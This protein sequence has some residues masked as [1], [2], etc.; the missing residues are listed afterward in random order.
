MKTIVILSMLTIL[1]TLTYS[2]SAMDEN[3]VVVRD[4]REAGR[5]KK[6]HMK[7]RT[8]NSKKKGKNGR[9]QM[10]TKTKMKNRQG[11]PRAFEDCVSKWLS[12]NL[13]LVGEL[14][15]KLIKIADNRRLIEKKA[16]KVFTHTFVI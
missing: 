14:K 10:K 1:V 9:R 3:K 13:T 4:G 12:F 11:M 2:R 7:K 5:K 15:R 8:R 6:N 16:T